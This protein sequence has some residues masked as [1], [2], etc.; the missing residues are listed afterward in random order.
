VIQ[1][2]SGTTLEQDVVIWAGGITGPSAM[3]ESSLKIE[4]SRVIAG[5]TF[6]TMDERVFATGDSALIEQVQ[7]TEETRAPPTA[8]AAWQAADTAALNIRRY[9]ENQ[10][11]ASWEYDD[12]GILISVGN[13]AIAHGIKGSPL[14]TFSGI[15]ARLLKKSVAARWVASLTSWPHAL[16]AWNAF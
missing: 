8:Q 5:S 1:F 13:Q 7:A 9:L 11:L 3:D 12:K 15:G 16:R 4:H 2:E 14:S 6:Q 10:P